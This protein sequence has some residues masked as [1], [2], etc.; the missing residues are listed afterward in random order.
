MITKVDSGDDRLNLLV[1][2]G[3]GE[4]HVFDLPSTTY[5]P[6]VEWSM[7]GYDYGNT[8]RYGGVEAILDGGGDDERRFAEH[9]TYPSLGSPNPVPFNPIQRISFYVPSRQDVSLKV[10]D[11]GG[12]LV[13]TIEEGLLDEGTQL[14]TWTGVDDRGAPV[15]TGVYFYRIRIGSY[16]DTRKTMM[17]K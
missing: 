16:E 17:L 12:R 1:Q 6:V 11:I 8:R 9:K 2:T 5:T 10:Y 15:A 13:K 7:Y 3:G 4:I 14:R